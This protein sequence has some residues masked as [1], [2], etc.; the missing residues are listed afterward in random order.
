MKLQKK[1]RFGILLLL[2]TIMACNR[3][4]HIPFLRQQGSAVQ[5]IVNEKPFIILGGELGNSTAS[6]LIDTK[7][8]FNKL[9]KLNLNTVLVPAY[10]EQ[11]ETEEGKFDFSLIDDIIDLAQQHDLKIVFL[12]FGAW[13]NS[14]SCYAPS[15]IKENYADYPRAV[16][17]TGKTLEILTAFDNNNLEAD[18][19]AFF[20][21]M[22][23]LAKIDKNRTVIMIQVENEI[24]MLESARDYCEKANQLFAAEVLKE[25]VD[26][27]IKNKQN[28]QL[29]LLEKW[30]ENNCPTTGT[31]TEFFGA[32]LETEELFMAWHYGLFIQ[33]IVKAGKEIYNLPMY[34]NA[35]LNSR[36]RKQGQYPSAGPLSHLLDLWRAASPDVDFISPDIYDPVFTDWCNQYHTNNNPLFIPEIRLEDANAARVFYAFG[37]HDAIGF[38]PFSIENVENAEEYP[39]AKSYTLLNQL[40]PLLSECQGLNKMNGILLDKNNKE[41]TVE[42]NG[43]AFTFRHDYTLGWDYRAK[44]ENNWNEVGALI[45]ELSPKEY[46]VAGTG[47]VLTFSNVRNDKTITGI[48]FID[49][50]EFKNEKMI[51]LRRLNGDQNHQGRH[52][53]IPVGVWNIQH[54][55][56]YDYK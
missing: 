49:E 29:H 31:W 40:S 15:W 35:A 34:V 16:T 53:R 56:L 23:H 38:S 21:F 55:K 18:K 45:I 27:L 11:T 52:L 30:E 33:E 5:L 42:R 13:K 17:E 41:C 46:I 36:G 7:A 4:E 37:E 50:V 54:I 39:L 28:L 2:I 3:S 10:W 44:D 19:R 14:M 51:S 47:I 8:A 1:I 26:Y 6:S 9:Q 43:Y 25:L 12:W 22:N 24:G 32:G 20:Q 48:S